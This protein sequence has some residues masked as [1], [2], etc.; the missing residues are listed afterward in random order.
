MDLLSCADDNQMQ[1]IRVHFAVVNATDSSSPASFAH[2][3]L[4]YADVQRA[5]EELRSPPLLLGG[6]V[7][8]GWNIR[9]ASDN[10]VSGAAC[11]EQ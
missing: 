8:N 7:V 3:S 4:V 6:L 9:R 2:A 5:L 11:T 10:A 1:G